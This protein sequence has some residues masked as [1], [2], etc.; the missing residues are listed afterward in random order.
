MLMSTSEVGAFALQGKQTQVDAQFNAV[1]LLAA[2]VKLKPEWLPE[3]LF[4]I[5]Y[6]RWKSPQR[7]AR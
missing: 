1:H 2:M 7:L 5:L 6:Q 4:E 3:Q